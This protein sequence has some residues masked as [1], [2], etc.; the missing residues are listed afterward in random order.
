MRFGLLI[1]LL[2]QFKKDILVVLTQLVIQRPGDFQHIEFI[3]SQLRR[4]IFGVLKPL[5][6][7]LVQQLG[8][9]IRQTIPTLFRCR[10]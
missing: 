1:P 10:H 2:R 4:F 3:K 9:P 8:R 6:R 5:N 7:P